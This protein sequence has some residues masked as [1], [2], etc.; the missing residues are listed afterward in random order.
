MTFGKA[1]LRGVRT[2]DVADT[3]HSDD[4]LPIDRYKWSQARIDRGMIDFLCCGI[5]LGDNDRTGSTTAFCTAQLRPS[6]T[7]A[8]K[9]FQQCDFRVG[10]IKD[11]FASVQEEP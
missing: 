9:V 3:F 4:M 7:N 8:S 10:R 11:D 5:V 2:L 6:K 1:L